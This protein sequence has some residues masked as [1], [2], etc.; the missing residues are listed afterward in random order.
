[1]EIWPRE[2]LFI[3]A[4]AVSAQSIFFLQ[5]FLR[6]NGRRDPDV[7]R[8]VYGLLYDRGEMSSLHCTSETGGTRARTLS[9][10]LSEQNPG[11]GNNTPLEGGGG[12]A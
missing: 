2:P 3:S 5:R 9:G 10:L 12:V 6:L 8:R 1:M 11:R 7:A 4:S